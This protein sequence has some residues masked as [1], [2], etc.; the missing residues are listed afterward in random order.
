MNMG[1][2]KMDRLLDVCVIYP[3]RF[4]TNDVGADTDTK[5]CTARKELGKQE[6]QM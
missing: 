3:T 5:M 6:D 4:R 2:L 1:K